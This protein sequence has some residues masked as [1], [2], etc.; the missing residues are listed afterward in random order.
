MVTSAGPGEG[1]TLTAI[2]LAL[3][4]AESYRYQ[5]LLVDADLRRPSISNV[6]DLG[7]GAG[8][9]EGL[10]SLTP[11]KL[12]LAQASL[13]DWPT[14]YDPP[15]VQVVAVDDIDLGEFLKR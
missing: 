7:A 14:I 6:V 3:V 5:V 2:N 11:Q 8:L 4:L 12:A 9:S 15:P 13:P 10:R 1:K